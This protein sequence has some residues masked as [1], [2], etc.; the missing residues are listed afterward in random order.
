MSIS[1]KDSN[2]KSYW[3]DERYR[4]LYNILAD[5]EGKDVWWFLDLK[6]SGHG[7]SVRPS[8]FL[9]VHRP[10]ADLIQEKRSWHLIILPY[11]YEALIQTHQSGKVGPKFTFNFSC[12]FLNPNIFPIWIPIVLI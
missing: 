1:F 8:P 2:G 12:M 7:D 5:V 9:C 3:F 4:D 6:K 11:G 10:F